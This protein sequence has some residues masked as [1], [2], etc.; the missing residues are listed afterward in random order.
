MTLLDRFRTQ[1][2][3]T[4]PDPAVRQEFVLELPMD[5]GSLLA[6]FARDDEDPR[7]R[8]AAVG[9]LMDPQTLAS[10]ART[11]RDE[12]VRAHALG[13]LRDI[14][15]EE[16]EGIGEAESLAAAAVVE[17]ART[18]SAIA[19]GAPR[20]AVARAALARLADARAFGSIARHGTHEAVRREALEAIG[21]RAEVLNVALNGEFKDTSAA[22][23]DRF[24][25]RADLEHIEARARNKHAARRARMRL[26]ELDERA[27]REAAEAAAAAAGDGVG[28]PPE[29]GVP[30]IASGEPATG[31]ISAPRQAADAVAPAADGGSVPL[32]PEAGAV[33]VSADQP[34]EAPLAAPRQADLDESARRAARLA[35]V[36]DA[37]ERA[38]TVEPIAAA[39]RQFAPL[40]R[41]W[42]QA[43]HPREL[44]PAA[45]A[46]YVAA[47]EAFDR[48]EAAAREL[49]QGAR[50]EALGRIQQLVGRA[51]AAAANADLPLKA[52]ERAVRDIRTALG[53]MPPLPSKADYED[54]LHRLK[55]A[56]AALAA[57]LKDLREIADWQRWANIGIQEQLCEKMEALAEVADPAEIS[58][59]VRDLQQHWRQAADVPRAQGEILWQRFKTAH[60][61]AWRRCEE[62][63]AAQEQARADNLAR[64]VVLCERAEALADSTSWIATAEEIKRLQAEWKTI[65]PV[66]RG[67]EKAIWER[68]RSACDRFFTRRQADLVQRKAVWA[69]NLVKK[70]ALCVRAEALAESTDWDGAAAEIKRL[71]AEWK[72]IGPVKPTR[73]EALWHRF[74]GA[75][76]RFF[77]RY[78]QRHDAARA[79][80]VTAREALCAELEQLAPA[81]DAGTAET[82]DR[83]PADIAARVRAIRGRW[84]QELAARGVDREQAAALD[85]RFGVAFA[86]VVASW[87]AVF[88]G[89]DLDPDANRKKMEL[90]VRRIEELAGSLAGAADD[91]LSPTTRLA[92]LLKEALASNTIGGRVD[93][94]GRWRAAVDDVRQAQAVWTRIGPVPD[95]VRRPLASRFERACRQ[96]TDRATGHA[97]GARRP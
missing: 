71:Q 6:A 81:D 41:E 78:A 43:G 63:F 60:D 69:A 84:Q 37:A 27:A 90:L 87:P 35:E 49:D 15:L 51:E 28:L 10:V 65:G 32:Q 31:S 73:S 58:R 53:S 74:R 12:G 56:Q 2:R 92:A 5:Q 25:E 44:D 11:D 17:D 26:R 59:A 48:R 42:H 4:H 23:V 52:V 66:S 33:P 14:A 97:A 34:S 96:I 93:E 47:E 67:Q 77:A 39:R 55:Q 30:P 21:D 45:A 50:R 79:E 72:T 40:R 89:T 61:T 46:R 57:K 64:K 85:R 8:K 20:E 9:K 70:D 7:V 22:A 83:P 29:A 80:R 36:A 19:K 38:V 68:F 62:Y 24:D 75:C 86:R 3:D 1:S 94:N 54:A 18:L 76:D 95:E 82:S 13:M 88:G 91:M 16:F